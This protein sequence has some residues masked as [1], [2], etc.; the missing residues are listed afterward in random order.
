MK[1]L[2]KYA[3]IAMIICGA[4]DAHAAIGGSVIVCQNSD[5]MGMAC[6]GVGEWR[7]STTN[8]YMQEYY[9]GLTSARCSIQTNACSCVS[10]LPA[11]FRCAT[12]YYG[13]PG[14]Y[15]T[16]TCT[17]CPPQGGVYGTTNPPADG[18]ETKI[19]DCYISSTGEQSDDTGIYTEE[20]ACYY[21]E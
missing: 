2:I 13:D 5:C 3:V 15:G 4:Y 10:D 1:S 18:G 17:R 14:L 19:T 9:P 16:G 8:V 20:G 11:R 7:I 6:T 12:G 21:T